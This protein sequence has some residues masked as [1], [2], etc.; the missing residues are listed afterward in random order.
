MALYENS[1][2]LTSESVAHGFNV[3]IEILPQPETATKHGNIFLPKKAY[4][5]LQAIMGKLVSVGEQAHEDGLCEGD[6]VMFD[7]DSAWGSPSIVA[8][9]LAVTHS[10]NVLVRILDHM[11]TDIQ[12]YGARVIV[13]DIQATEVQIG[14]IYLP[15]ESQTKSNV[16]KIHKLGTGRFKGD[17]CITEFPFKVG[18]KAVIEWT[19]TIK[20]T[21]SGKLKTVVDLRFFKALIK[22]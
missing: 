19:K 17:K 9:V 13:D 18:D 12:P 11:G 22:E 8:G 1:V 15:D 2:Q 7:K 6:V 4:E 21:V 3:I 5:G 16:V 10:E 20:I 14:G